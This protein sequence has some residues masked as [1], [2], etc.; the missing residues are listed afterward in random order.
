MRP[1][2]LQKFVIKLVLAGAAV[3]ALTAA[4]VGME[5]KV[6][7]GLALSNAEQ[8]ISTGT[9]KDPVPRVLVEAR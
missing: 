1:N 6:T 9:L 3:I 7:N 8:E 2:D 5:T 4:M